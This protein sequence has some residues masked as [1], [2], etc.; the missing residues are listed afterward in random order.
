MRTVLQ[1]FL[2]NQ[3][4]SRFTQINLLNKGVSKVRFYFETPFLA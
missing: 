1:I 4:S 3:I 2:M